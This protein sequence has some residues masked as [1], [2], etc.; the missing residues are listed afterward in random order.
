MGACLPPYMKSFN[1]KIHCFFITFLKVFSL[2]QYLSKAIT[3]TCKFLPDLTYFFST[4]GPRLKKNKKQRTK[5]HKK[6][7]TRFQEESGIS[8]KM[9]GDGKNLPESRGLQSGEGVE[10][11]NDGS[12]NGFGRKTEKGRLVPVAKESKVP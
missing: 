1:S 8:K 5:L 4:E 3:L 11:K 10:R 6:Y 12:R 9:E 7:E 2:D